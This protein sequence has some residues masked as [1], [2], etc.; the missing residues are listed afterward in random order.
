MSVTVENVLLNFNPDG[1]IECQDD[2]E[3]NLLRG[4]IKFSGSSSKR[5]NVIQRK[6]NTDFSVND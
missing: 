3:S 2:D 5:A 6:K 1:E 4:E